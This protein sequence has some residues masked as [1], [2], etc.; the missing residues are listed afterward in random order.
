MFQATP[1]AA[2][3]KTGPTGLAARG[4]AGDVG[5][6]VVVLRLQVDVYCS[7][8]TWKTDDTGACTYDF[9]GASGTC[10]ALYYLLSRR[11]IKVEFRIVGQVRGFAV[12]LLVD[13]LGMKGYINSHPH[14]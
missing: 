14:T 11:D 9:S 1:F 6:A 13:G 3:L 10:L 2:Q 4:E 7:D 8:A 5:V 12:T